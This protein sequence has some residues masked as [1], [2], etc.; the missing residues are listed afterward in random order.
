M[1]EVVHPAPWYTPEG[2]IFAAVPSSRDV[3]YSLQLL[4]GSN[5]KE[6]RAACHSQELGEALR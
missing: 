5:L 2:T 3:L 6:V 4:Y 1:I